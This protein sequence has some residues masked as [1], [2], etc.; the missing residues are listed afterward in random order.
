MATENYRKKKHNQL[1][2]RV[3][4]VDQVHAMA[5][6]PKAATRRD[7]RAALKALKDHRAIAVRKARADRREIEKA[8]VIEVLVIRVLA[9]RDVVPVVDRLKVAVGSEGLEVVDREVREGPTVFKVLIQSDS[10]RWQWSSTQT[11]TVSSIEMSFLSL[12]KAI[13]RCNPV[14][15]R[16][17]LARVFACRLIRSWRH[18]I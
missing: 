12:L 6:V 18:W 8:A 2:D 9:L 13:Q 4:C 5:I 3:D 10:S 16:A 11:K 1:S 7:D 15:A 14:D 17:A